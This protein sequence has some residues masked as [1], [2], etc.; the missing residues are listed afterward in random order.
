[1]LGYSYWGRLGADI[2]IVFLE[3]KISVLTQYCY[4]LYVRSAKSGESTRC[5]WSASSSDTTIVAL[6][7]QA[8]MEQQVFALPL[9]QR[10]TESIWLVMG[11]QQR[12]QHRNLMKSD[13]VLY[14]IV[15]YQLPTK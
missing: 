5:S 11:K 13:H 15:R 10:G 8:R 7:Y 12:F 2:V 1:M 14:C 9:E 3:R 6:T 4:T